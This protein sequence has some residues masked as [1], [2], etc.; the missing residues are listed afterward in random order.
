MSQG[1]PATGAGWL[2]HFAI[3][4]LRT[5]AASGVIVCCVALAGPLSAQQS[6]L[7]GTGHAL[8]SASAPP[9]VVAAAQWA[10]GKP[11]VGTLTAVSIEGPPGLKVG[12]ARDG[13]F[14]A[15]ITAPVTTAML[16]GATYRFRVTN[17]PYREGLELFPTLEVID[18][19]YSPAGREHRFPIPVV[20]TEED[21]ELAL[22]GALVT[23]VIY[24]EDSHSAAPWTTL[25]GQQM[26]TD[27]SPRDNALHTADLLGRP[28]AILR[29]GSRVPNDL[30]NDLSDFTCGCPPWL[31]LQ[32]APNRDA[33]IKQGRWPEM[34]PVQRPEAIYSEGTGENIP[35][36]RLHD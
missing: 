32:V 23:R 5:V 14:L 21:L 22:D 4:G 35:R 36:V 20:L 7:R 3:R 6:N 30:A 12:L 1:K 15:P 2:I 18:R 16:V 25:P 19:V 34:Q 28:V 11:S 13:Q 24:V 27:V 33:M 8:L 9:G 31:P 26:T 29:I 10:G 17:I